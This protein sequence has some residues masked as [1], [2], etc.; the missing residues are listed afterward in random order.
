MSSAVQMALAS[1]LIGSVMVLM[2]VYMLQTRQIAHSAGMKSSGTVWMK[3][4]NYAVSA[5]EGYIILK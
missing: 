3:L 5:V 4:F 1:Q 2:T